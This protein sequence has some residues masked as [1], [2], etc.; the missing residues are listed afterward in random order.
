MCTLENV[1][2]YDTSIHSEAEQTNKLAREYFAAVY[3][4]RRA[5]IFPALH[6][7]AFLSSHSFVRLNSAAERIVLFSIWGGK[8]NVTFSRNGLLFL[9][10]VTDLFYARICCFEHTQNGFYRFIK[11][12]WIFYLSTWN[13]KSTKVV[14][15]MSGK[16]V[17]VWRAHDCYLLLYPMTPLESHWGRQRLSVCTIL[18]KPHSSDT[19]AAF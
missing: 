11:L 13:K 10:Y 17:F 4:P 9:R 18:T 5:T 2:K 19:T 12:I 6:S 1:L 8:W 14:M 16:M 7:R 3:H 15:I